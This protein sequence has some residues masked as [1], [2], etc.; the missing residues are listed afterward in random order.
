M[1]F[2]ARL[3]H[4]VEIQRATA[5]AADDYGQPARTFASIGTERCLIQ[6]KS[7]RELAQVN[8]AGPVRGEYRV[9]MLPTDVTE[10]DHLVRQDTAEVFEIGFVADAAG[11]GH[12]L[13]LDASKVWP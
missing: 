12:H 5:G 7:G 9:F 3:I 11:V 6:P 1:T 4:T 2:R 8:E 13:E 10:A